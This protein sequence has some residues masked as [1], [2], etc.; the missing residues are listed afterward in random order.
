[1]RLTIIGILVI[2]LGIAMVIIGS[3]SSMPTS[4]PQ[5]ASSQPSVGGVVLIGPFPIIFGYGNSA[6]ITPLIALGV[7]FTLIVL[8]F[9][10]INIYVMRKMAENR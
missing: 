7:V 1:M 10:L 4:V 8:A 3:L 5:T 9:Y 2:L 6:Q